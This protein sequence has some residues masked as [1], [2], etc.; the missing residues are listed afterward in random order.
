M[1]VGVL[2][3]PLEG[4]HGAAQR[5]QVLQ[6]A[7]GIGAPLG[8]RRVVAHVLVVGDQP[9]RQRHHRDH[10][11]TQRTSGVELGSDALKA[12]PELDQA[13]AG[14]RAWH[15]LDCSGAGARRDQVATKALARASNQGVCGCRP[16]PPPG[17]LD[18]PPE[19]LRVARVDE[20]RQVR[21]RV[22]DLRALIQAQRPEHA[23][24]DA[25]ARQGVL[26]RLGRV[27]GPGEREH[28]GR[29][30][31]GIKRVGDLPRGP[32]RLLILVGQAQDPHLSPGPAHRDQRLRGAALVV[33]HA[34]DRRFEDLRARAEV[35]PQHDAGVSRVAFGKAEDV[36]RIGVAPA[37]DHLADA[38]CWNEQHMDD[39]TAEHG[40]RV[41]IPPDSGK[42]KG[43]R[44]GWTGG[45]YSFMRR[46]LATDLGKELYRKRQQSIE[47]VYGHT[48][49]NRRFDCF[50]RRGRL[51]VR[52][53]WRLITMSHNLTK[54][55]RH[56][57]AALK[58]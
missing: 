35:S 25:A 8:A 41:L 34:A 32:L 31:A 53:E 16:N 26:K 22:P 3:L 29:R 44:P 28:L 51:A 4:L 23:V 38:Q 54:L 55:H 33:A 1:S 21:Q 50:H 47:L 58:A 12:H 2:V 13:A 11:V 24:R 49:R 43:E 18:R 42:R 56:Q 9:S 30:H 40:I 17:R 5:P 37:V 52:T 19:R 7:L 27:A 14:R 15:P 46:V 57:V 39:V 6:H 45:R 36:P 10:D 20:Q 48:K